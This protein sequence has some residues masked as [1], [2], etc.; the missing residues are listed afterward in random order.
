[1]CFCQGRAGPGGLILHQV[2]YRFRKKKAVS[3]EE[4]RALEGEEYVTGFEYAGADRLTS[5]L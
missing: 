3:Y 4:R 5:M 1:M 2:V